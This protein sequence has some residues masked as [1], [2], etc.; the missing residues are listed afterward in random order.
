MSF[1]PLLHSPTQ[2]IYWT[3]TELGT[4]EDMYNPLGPLKEWQTNKTKKLGDSQLP[5]FKTYYKTEVKQCITGI[6]IYV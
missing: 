5:D 6:N 1:K 2:H 4:G 3:F